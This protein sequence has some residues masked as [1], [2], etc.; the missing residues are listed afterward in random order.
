M[1]PNRAINGRVIRP[2]CL[3]RALHSGW[4]LR[5]FL[6]IFI[7][8]PRFT[9]SLSLLVYFTGLGD[10]VFYIF[11]SKITAKCSYKSECFNGNVR[12]L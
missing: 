7:R 9:S 4:R 11:G 2:E 3:L 1:C 10:F 6:R 8:V 12:I 5:G